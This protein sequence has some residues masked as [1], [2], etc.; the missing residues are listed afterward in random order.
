[1]TTEF[2]LVLKVYGNGSRFTVQV[3]VQN[4]RGSTLLRHERHATDISVASLASENARGAGRAR[5]A[6]GRSVNLVCLVFLLRY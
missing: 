5:L 3:E 1:M 6:R 4:I 2:R